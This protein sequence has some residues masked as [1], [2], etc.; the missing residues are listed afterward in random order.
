MGG[1]RE[2]GGHRCCRAAQMRPGLEEK[3]RRRARASGGINTQSHT[4]YCSDSE[5][6]TDGRRS[7]SLLIKYVFHIHNRLS[8]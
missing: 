1:A 5:L 7:K 4:G 3:V 8:T 6:F 2:E